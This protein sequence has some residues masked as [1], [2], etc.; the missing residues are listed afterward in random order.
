MMMVKTTKFEF[1]IKKKKN[2]TKQNNKN[3]MLL[4]FV[5]S[6][7]SYDAKCSSDQVV[8]LQMN[9]RFFT[10]QKGRNIFCCFLES[11]G[12]AVVKV[13]VRLP[14]STSMWVEFVCSLLCSERFSPRY[15]NFPLSSKNRHLIWFDSRRMMKSKNERVNSFSLFR[16]FCQ[17]GKILVE[18]EKKI[19][20]QPGNSITCV[21]CF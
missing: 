7:S 15:S 6:H 12:G 2:K 10:N 3:I 20:S 5:F 16:F 13:R 11:S 9:D 8:Y 4:R 18:R 1:W 14:D 19:T 21:Y 17:A